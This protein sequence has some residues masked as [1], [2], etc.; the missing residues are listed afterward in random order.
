MTSFF[1]PFAILA[2]P[3]LV[4]LQCSTGMV[5]F[6][7]TWSAASCVEAAVNPPSSIIILKPKKSAQ[8]VADEFTKKAAQAKEMAQVAK[9]KEDVEDLNK[10]NKNLQ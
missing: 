3:R 4:C 5:A 8:K 10:A 6:H 9:Q 7:D 2:K 1:F